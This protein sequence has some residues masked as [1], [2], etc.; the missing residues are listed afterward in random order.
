MPAGDEEGDDDPTVR[1]LRDAEG[2]DVDEN[3][4]PVG[5][6]P[7]LRQGEG[8]DQMINLPVKVGTEISCGH[9]KTT[10]FLPFNFRGS[11]P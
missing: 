9:E 6:L 10:R 1:L 4:L 11:T 2:C 5:T 3:N 7:L 8:V